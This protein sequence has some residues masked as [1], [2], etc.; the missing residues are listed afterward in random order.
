MIG[1]V[2]SISYTVTA[3]TLTLINKSILTIFE[4]NYPNLMVLF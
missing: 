3:V 2:S 1:L 4:F